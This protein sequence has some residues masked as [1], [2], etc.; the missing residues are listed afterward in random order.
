MQL[1]PRTTKFSFWLLA[2]V[3][4]V[5]LCRRISGYIS[6]D[7]TVMSSCHWQEN[8]I[9]QS[10]SFTHHIQC[11]NKPT[12][13]FTSFVVFLLNLG[14]CS[15][16]PFMVSCWSH[17]QPS[18]TCLLVFTTRQGRSSWLSLLLQTLYSWLCSAYST[19][20]SPLSPALRHLQDICHASLKSFIVHML[21]L[22]LFINLCL[23]IRVLSRLFG[24]SSIFLLWVKVITILDTTPFILS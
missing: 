20:E 9:Y 23:K 10:I 7:Q 11:V 1:C 19:S 16:S 3:T 4:V 15:V 5:Y 6:H 8:R 13:L 17:W 12:Q 22:C 21:L 18:N 24:S 14:S 2:V